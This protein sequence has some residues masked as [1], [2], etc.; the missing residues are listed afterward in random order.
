MGVVHNPLVGSPLIETSKVAQ[1]VLSYI[2][3]LINV[4]VLSAG[5]TAV[6]SLALLNL[7]LFM[8]F[9]KILKP[10]LKFCFVVLV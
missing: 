4:K 7:V 10:D 2:W 3:G 6:K 5:K 9:S 8:Q 1:W